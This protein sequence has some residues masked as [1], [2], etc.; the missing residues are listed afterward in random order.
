MHKTIS[1]S[2]F[3]KKITFTP[4]YYTY[5]YENKNEVYCI[6]EANRV[7]K[8]LIM[9]HSNHDELTFISSAGSDTLNFVIEH[10]E[11]V[12]I[13]ITFLVSDIGQDEEIYGLTHVKM[14]ISELV[15]K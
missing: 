1:L 8:V 6:V 9:E 12:K 14:K 2:V 13:K 11:Y 3:M 5:R 15:S 10:S 4:Y 7:K